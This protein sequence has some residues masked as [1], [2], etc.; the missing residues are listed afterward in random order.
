LLARLVQ[1]GIRVRDFHV[2][3]QTIEDIF[4]KIGAHQVS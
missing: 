4:M 3:R 2:R 1:G